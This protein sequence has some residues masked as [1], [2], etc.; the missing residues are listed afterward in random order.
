MRKPKAK[1]SSLACSSSVR[2]PTRRF[3]KKCTYITPQKQ[4]NDLQ[5]FIKLKSHLRKLPVKSQD[6]TLDE[7]AERSPMHKAT[8]VFLKA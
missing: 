5:S 8:E 7:L 4:R 2:V 1:R 6:Q 3:R